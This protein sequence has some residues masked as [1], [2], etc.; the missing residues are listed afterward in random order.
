M[1]VSNTD[2]GWNK[3]QNLPFQVVAQQRNPIHIMLQFLSCKFGG[4]S[5][6]N[7]CRRVLRTCTPSAFLMAA[8]NKR[9]QLHA[10]AHVK[11]ADS[12]GTVHFVCRNREHIDLSFTDIHFD[13]SRSLNSIAVKQGS[14][15]VR[16]GRKHL[17]GKQNSSLIVGPLNGNEGCPLT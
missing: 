3:A 15:R 6:A 11:S 13:S 12:F 10:V 14:G 8:I 4:R 17:N 7:D 1:T 5:E 16:D 9:R 2:S